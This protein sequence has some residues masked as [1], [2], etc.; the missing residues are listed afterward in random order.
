[1]ACA[2]NHDQLAGL[3][4]ADAV[5]SS[6]FFAVNKTQYGEVEPRYMKL[7]GPTA[8]RHSGSAMGYGLKLWPPGMSSKTETLEHLAELERL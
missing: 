6:M 7:L 8:Y 3:Q 5:A 2:V 1:M 4:I